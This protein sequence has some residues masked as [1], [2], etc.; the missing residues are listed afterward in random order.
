MTP[1]EREL[2]TG[3]FDRL[4]TLESQPRDVE[5]ERVIA[6]G[7]TLAPNA[8]YPLV[9]TVLVQ[10]EALRQAHERIQELEARLG[11]PPQQGEGFLDRMRP[12]SLGRGELRGG[13]VP[14]VRS[15]PAWN[16]GAT[17]VGLQ[18]PPNDERRG[19]S[20]L[21]TAAAAAVGAIGGSLLFDSLRSMM[22]GRGTQAAAFGG[23]DR[24]PWAGDASRSDLAREAGLNDVGSP[25]R[26]SARDDNRAASLF[27]DQ[28]D[29][30]DDDFDT[31]FDDGDFGDSEA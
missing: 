22:G 19:G 9:Q 3:L 11:A 16:T 28:T 2:V 27:D 30:G 4:A 8:I 14:S 1:Q 25:T 13:S 29:E 7:A 10:D 12:S 17:G 31:D 20:F 15:A 6:A 24:S 21:G 18:Q 23:E 5:A 26:V